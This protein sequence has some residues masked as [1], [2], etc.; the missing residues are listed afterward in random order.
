VT[1]LFMVSACVTV[2]VL[3]HPASPVHAAID[4]CGW[5]GSRLLG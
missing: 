5:R 4:A 2:V 1:A 3:E